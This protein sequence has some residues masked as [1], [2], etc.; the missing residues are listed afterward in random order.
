MF[1]EKRFCIAEEQ[2][3]R[4]CFLDAAFFVAPWAVFK[5]QSNPDQ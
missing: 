3:N 1:A 4:K 2:T 5:F